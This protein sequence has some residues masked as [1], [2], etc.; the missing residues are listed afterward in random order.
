MAGIPAN[1]REWGMLEAGLEKQAPFLAS[2]EMHP[3]RAQVREALHLSFSISPTAQALATRS[4]LLVLAPRTWKLDLNGAFPEIF[5]FFAVWK[6]GYGNGR[7]CLVKAEASAEG[8]SA[9]CALIPVG[10]EFLVHVKTDGA[11]LP[12]G[13][14]LRIYLAHP[15]GARVRAPQTVQFHPFVT[16]VRFADETAFRPLS[17]TPGVTLYGGYARSLRITG[18]SVVE[19]GEAALLK[20]APMDQFGMNRACDYEGEVEVA[21]VDGSGQARAVSIGKDAPFARVTVPLTGHSGFHYVRALDLSHDL[22]GRSHPIGHPDAFGGYRVFFG[23]LHVHCRPCD[24][25]GTMQEAYD[26]AYE[27]S[28]LDFAAVS[29]QQNSSNFPFTPAHWE[30]YLEINERFNG[31]DAFATLPICEVYSAYGHRHAL[32]RSVADARRFPVG[33]S[34]WGETPYDP[35]NRPEKLWQTL[36]GMAALTFPHH[37]KFIHGTDFSVPP[38][39]MEPVM[40]I[41]SRW[42]ISEC[43]GT[44][45]AQYALSQGRRMGFIGGTDNHLGQPGS[46]T[47]GYNEGR[48]WIAVLT[49]SLDREAIF[50]AIRTRRCYATTGAKMLLFVTMGDRVM[51]E[52]APGWTGERRIL[53]RAAGTRPIDR[54]EVIRNGETVYEERPEAYTVETEYCDADPV[55]PLFRQPAFPELASFC[56][57]YIR[58]TQ[59]DGNQAWSSPI[60][61][62]P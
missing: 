53:I 49:K 62:C 7:Q 5:Q 26:Y 48:G 42:G 2:V 61:V 54:V 51:G 32:F 59:R 15:D 29:H 46:G 6:G 1:R 22:M 28:D 17:P 37:M 12:E 35:A 13:E 50:D 41:C 27:V 57:Y 10:F 43:G 3:D 24:G 38:N 14:T 8:V 19:P 60:W 16:A 34:Y 4:D 40:E 18:Q 45:S 33:M 44:H 36:D 23:D 39:P 25:F 11:D 21:E 31:M 30:D 9:T 58:I 20:V 55:A 47:H 56:Y 52:E